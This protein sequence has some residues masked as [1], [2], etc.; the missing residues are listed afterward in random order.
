M[1]VLGVTVP[2]RKQKNQAG[3]PVPAYGEIFASAIGGSLNGGS[4]INPSVQMGVVQLV[5]VQLGVVQ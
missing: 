3:T 1:S 5:V 4:P 2:A